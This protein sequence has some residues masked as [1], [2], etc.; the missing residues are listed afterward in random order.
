MDE[1]IPLGQTLTRDDGTVVERV[2]VVSGRGVWAYHRLPQHTFCHQVIADILYN[3][4][5][6]HFA[7]KLDLIY[8]GPAPEEQWLIV[9]GFQE[10][11]HET[12]KY[13]EDEDYGLPRMER[14]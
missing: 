4:H 1:P 10:P 12:R 13:V 6:T 8:R 7:G 11:A 14:R 9:E 2:L 5:A 3:R